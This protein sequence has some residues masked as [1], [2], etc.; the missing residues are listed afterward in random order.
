MQV[1]SLSSPFAVDAEAEEAFADRV[2]VSLGLCP[3][4]CRATVQTVVPFFPP[5]VKLGWGT[6][7][8]GMSD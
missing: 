6:L 1:Y 2:I 5:N 3:V 4:F 7:E 8:L